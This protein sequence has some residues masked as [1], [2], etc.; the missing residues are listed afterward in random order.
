MRKIYKYE[1]EQTIEMPVGAE[2]LTIQLQHD[3]PNLWAV[4]DTEIEEK[5]TR[6]FA[7][8]GTGHAMEDGDMKYIGTFQLFDGG[9]VGHVFEK[10]II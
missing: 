7:I 2:I 1:I 8:V 9:F 10:L 4:V 5:E 3:I 6:N